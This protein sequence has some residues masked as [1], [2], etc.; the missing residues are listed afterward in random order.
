MMSRKQ[1]R[2]CPAASCFVSADGASQP[3]R[4]RRRGGWRRLGAGATLLRQALMHWHC[5]RRMLGESAYT[6]AIERQLLAITSEMAICTGWLDGGNVQLARYLYAEAHLT[7]GHAGNPVVAAHALEKWSMLCCYLAR[8]AGA[9]NE[10]R[11]LA[12]EGLRLALQAADQAR[13]E[14]IPRL[15]A[16]IA[17]RQANAASLLG[18][19]AAFRSAI[20]RARR[21][22]E[23]G[24]R[25]DDPKWIGFV[26]ETEITGHEAMG[27]LNLRKPARGETLYRTVLDHN[28]SRRNRTYYGALLSGALLKQDAPEHAIAAGMNVLP[29]LADGVTSVRALDELRPLRTAGGP[30]TDERAAFVSSS[31]PLPGLWPRDDVHRRH[32][33]RSVVPAL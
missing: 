26:D 1:I 27:V 13:Y 6:A 11:S 10:R 9:A 23:R 28:L 22:A 25:P 31:T 19:E 2:E 32:D 14:P 12:R 15:H 21:E 5:A 7:A 20:S 33:P 4:R 30:P 8:T 18:D 24:P 17:M 3:E 29:V 16:L